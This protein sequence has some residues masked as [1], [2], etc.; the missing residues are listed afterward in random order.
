MVIAMIKKHNI[1]YISIIEGIVG[2]KA[3]GMLTELIKDNLL[4]IDLISEEDIKIFVD[5]IAKKKVIFT[6]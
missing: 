2:Q 4:I 1:K 3:T 6:F 5:C